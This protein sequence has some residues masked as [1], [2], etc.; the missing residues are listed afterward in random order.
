MR[1]IILLIIIAC[2]VRIIL[3]FVMNDSLVL[4]GD[5]SRN[6]QT[7]LNHV[8]GFGY[9]ILQNGKYVPTAFHSSFAVLMYEALILINISKEFIAL[10]IWI[11]SFLFYAAS[12]LFFYRL[13]ELYLSRFRFAAT[14]AYCFYPSVIYFIG[15]ISLYEN[16]VLPLL[17]INFYFLMTGTHK[18]FV[19]ASSVLSCLVRPNILP[20]YA[21]LL[22]FHALHKKK[23]EIPAYAC[24]FFLLLNIPV[25]IKNKNTFGN[26]FLS[27][28]AGFEFLQGHS[29]VAR[30]SWTVIYGRKESPLYQYAH[31]NIP[32]IDTMNEFRESLAR[33]NLAWK[34][35]KE[36]PLG[37]MKLAFRKVLIYFAPYNLKGLWGSDI[38]NPLNF[39][40]HLFFVLWLITAARSYQNV[41]LVAPAA[42][43][44]IT[45]LVFFVGYRWRFYAEPFMIIAA[46][47][48]L[49]RFGR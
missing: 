46:F 36:N 10:L 9:S 28:Q 18:I 41:M 35:I 43:S 30:G 42:A 7:A 3:I 45:S 31:A 25:L 38:F 29:P 23:I 19:I 21:L 44:I 4:G 13:T 15:S 39:L 27:T 20:V 22:L 17:V 16:I 2:A 37:E 1:K 5:E 32:G 40:V 33:Q 34:W 48:Y 12:I 24:L 14:V 26:Y 8:N 6:Y 11:L 49:K 47:S